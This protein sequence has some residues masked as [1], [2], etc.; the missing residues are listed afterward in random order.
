MAERQLSDHS[1]STRFY[2]ILADLFM[3]S[4]AFVTVEM[5]VMND[6]W[7]I[8]LLCWFLAYVISVVIFVPSA[9]DRL[10]KSVHI[11]GR[12]IATSILMAVLFV[13]ENSIILQV[14]LT[15][16]EL[17][18]ILMAI[19]CALVFSRS[20]SR[21]ILK[22]LR[23]HGQDNL[24]VVMVGEANSLRDLYDRMGNDLSVGYT[25][26]GYFNSKRVPE[27]DEVLEYKGNVKEVC[28][29]LSGNQIDMVFCSPDSFDTEETTRLMDF[30][31]NN[32]VHFYSVPNLPSYRHRRMNVEYVY[33]IP[34]MTIRREPLA[35]SFNRLQK[36]VFDV[37]FSALFLLLCYWWIYIIVAIVTKLTMPGPVIF[38]QKRNGQYGETFICYKF[39]SMK[40]N[41]DS[42]LL[43]AT[44]ND[45]RKTR[46][47][48]I[49][50]KT[51]ID[52]LPQFVNVLKGE[53]SIVGPRPHML[54][55]TEE[56]RKLV[57]KYMVRHY[58]KP[59]ITGW[60]QVTGSRG[61]TS[62]LW[63]ME[64]RIQKDIWYVENWSMLLDVIIIIK[65]ILN[66]L[67]QE[68]GNAY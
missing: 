41:K 9:Q 38:K 24:N 46:W 7:N 49:L 3:L 32:L 37:L 20:A 50:R 61:E 45:P 39:R 47:G 14:R 19:T 66:V 34:I 28:D 1:R 18:S 43:Q 29:F 54:K 65:T 12:S 26:V 17:M 64:E 68:K 30:C 2:L 8:R 5:H 67:G 53:M 16:F 31:E 44:K 58:A 51:N 13:V 4:V 25:I 33:E 62:E 48:S 40:V 35:S 59:G 52:E 56:Y 11:I 57:D 63:M 55:H 10:V 6:G 42:D 21:L 23:K 27:L 15:F 60:A 22:R 36:R